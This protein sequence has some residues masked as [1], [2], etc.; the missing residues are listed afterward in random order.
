MATPLLVRMMCRYV[1]VQLC[2]H[3]H[4]CVY[5]WR[6]TLNINVKTETEIIVDVL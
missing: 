3:V 1:G 4:V 5:V 6:M 2:M